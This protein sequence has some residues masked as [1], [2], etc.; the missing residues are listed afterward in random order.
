M[1]GQPSGGRGADRTSKRDGEVGGRVGRVATGSLSKARAVE[2]VATRKVIP[3]VKGLMAHGVARQG[4]SLPPKRC[5]SSTLAARLST[6][7]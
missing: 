6:T 4:I 2:A 1:P 3:V 5:S 7:I